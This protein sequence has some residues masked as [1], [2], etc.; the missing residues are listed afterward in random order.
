MSTVG[1]VPVQ[2]KTSNQGKSK[3]RY[4]RKHVDF[5][6]LIKKMKLWPSRKG[7]LHGV[8]S[9]KIM[10]NY[11]TITTH[12][13]QTFMIRNSKKSRA[14]RWLR[15]KWFTATCKKCRIPGWKLEKFSETCF[16]EHW[17]SQLTEVVTSEKSSHRP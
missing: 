3:K 2:E 11:A 10:G 13:N 16:T 14:A 15:N 7:I 6:R 5:F 4:Y 9:F 17:G 12:C 8:R 1:E